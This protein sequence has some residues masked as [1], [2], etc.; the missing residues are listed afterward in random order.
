MRT[1][2]PAIRVATGLE[3]GWRPPPPAP[4][5]S[6]TR[7]TRAPLA[8]DPR[9]AALAHCKCASGQQTFFRGRPGTATAH[10]VD[11]AS[12]PSDPGR[13]GLLLMVH[14]MTPGRPYRRRVTSPTHSPTT[15][16]SV[17]PATTAWGGAAAV[18]LVPVGWPVVATIAT[19]DV[20]HLK[21]LILLA[22]FML[23]AALAVAAFGL[24][25]GALA[26][27]PD[28]LLRNRPR[29]RPLGAVSAVVIVS[30]SVGGAF[31]SATVATSTV[32]LLLPLPALPSLAIATGAAAA[33][34][35]VVIA[36]HRR[37]ERRRAARAAQAAQAPLAHTWSLP[38][39]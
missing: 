24:A 15:L 27:L 37:R 19:G 2:H 1:L 25:V 20:E 12:R 23:V 4:E 38:A 3:R 34:T 31:A 18:L 39:P 17:L 29:L 32:F 9:L 30:A 35:T 36:I 6:R 8:L 16:L 33:S 13:M 7:Y 21:F 28:R 11:A 26:G 5:A 14:P 10:S 22:P